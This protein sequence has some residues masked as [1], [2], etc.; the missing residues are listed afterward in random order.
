MGINAPRHGQAMGDQPG[1]VPVYHFYREIERGYQEEEQQFWLEAKV[2]IIPFILQSPREGEYDRKKQKKGAERKIP[3]S[4]ILKA[5]FD[6]D[7]I[8]GP[9]KGND[10]GDGNE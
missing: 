4:Q 10:E 2:F 3:V 8:I 7:G 9:D 1:E 5:A 6:A